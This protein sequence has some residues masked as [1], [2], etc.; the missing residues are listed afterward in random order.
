M[1]IDDVATTVANA[2]KEVGPRLTRSRL[3]EVA[4]S[5]E[6]EPGR[7]LGQFAFGSIS[8][9]TDLGR[10]DGPTL[11]G[12]FTVRHEYTMIKAVALPDGSV[13]V[14]KGF[15]DTDDVS[16][17]DGPTEGGEHHV[18][19]VAQWHM[20]PPN[21]FTVGLV[22]QRWR[23]GLPFVGVR[24]VRPQAVLVDA[25]SLIRFVSFEVVAILLLDIERAGTLPEG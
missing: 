3:E 17:W 23:D 14:W 20:F 25:P 1:G 18:N 12:G 10:P 8:W 15:V 9:S 7:T 2:L 16:I 5:I 19:F 4:G 22:R 24:S 21:R 11:A 6:Q 13:D